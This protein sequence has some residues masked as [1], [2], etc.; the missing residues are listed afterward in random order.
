MGGVLVQLLS[1]SIP[2]TVV[3][4]HLAVKHPTANYIKIHVL[5]SLSSIQLPCVVTHA[6]CSKTS[7]VCYRDIQL[8]SVYINKCYLFHERNKV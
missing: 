6:I 1:V 8:L 3:S 7:D 4:I 5:L 2:L